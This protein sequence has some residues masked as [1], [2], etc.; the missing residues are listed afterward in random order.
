MSRNL[1]SLKKKSKKSLK[2]EICKN[3]TLKKLSKKPDILK[4]NILNNNNNKINNIVR[5]KIWDSSNN[6]NKK[7]ISEYL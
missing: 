3:F 2:M 4:N 5:A 7:R 1:N 6:N